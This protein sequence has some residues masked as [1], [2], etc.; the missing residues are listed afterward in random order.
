MITFRLTGSLGG[1]RF[2]PRAKEHFNQGRCDENLKQMNRPWPGIL[3]L[4]AGILGGMAMVNIL[5][6]GKQAERLAREVS[7]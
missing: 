6:V 1:E 3:I 7:A 4:I 2:K 5:T